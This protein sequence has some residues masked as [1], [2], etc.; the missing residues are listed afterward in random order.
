[1]FG[2]KYSYLATAV[3][4]LFAVLLLVLDTP[5]WMIVSFLFIFRERVEGKYKISGS[6]KTWKKNWLMFKRLVNR[7][8]WYQWVMP[9]AVAL[10]V[11][12]A[13]GGRLW[14]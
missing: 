14:F 2:I 10:L 5:P 13:T 12:L 11:T 8:V 6:V 4:T 9:T 1:M 7:D 3:H